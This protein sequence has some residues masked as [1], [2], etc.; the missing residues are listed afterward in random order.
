MYGLDTQLGL[1]ADFVGKI[2]DVTLSE[3]KG[4]RG[5]V[6][7]PLTRLFTH[8]RRVQSDVQ[9]SFAVARPLYLVMVKA[10]ETV[11]AALCASR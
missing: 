4:L 6:A 2:F 1:R 3:A 10:Q 11:V 8:L 5:A 9:A 7:T